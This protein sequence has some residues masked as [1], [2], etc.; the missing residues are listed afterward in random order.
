MNE[1]DSITSPWIRTSDNLEQTQKLAK[2]L[3]ELLRPSGV[4][5]F[6]GDL[7][8][9][10]TTMIQAMLWHLGYKGSVKS[11]T[12]DLLH[13]YEFYPFRVYHVDLY[14]LS[15]PDELAV[16]DLPEPGEENTM[17]LVEWG[18]MLTTL[19]PDYFQLTCEACGDTC[20]RFT[21]EAHGE[22]VQQRYATWL[23]RHSIS[24]KEI[25]S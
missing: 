21:L 15:S 5:L 22:T 16:L 20:R 17:I 10:K 18:E 3:I 14:R 25:N 6:A 1:K 2:S 4:M 11:P 24:E 12:F 13:L 7:G 23:S 19:Y 8:T 9:G